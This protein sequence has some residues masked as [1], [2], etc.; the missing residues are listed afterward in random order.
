MLRYASAIAYSIAVSFQAQGLMSP[1]C[2][3]QEGGALAPPPQ[4]GGGEL[5]LLLG[6]DDSN[7]TVGSVKTE[8][9]TDPRVSVAPKDC[10]IVIEDEVHP[11][12]E[13]DSH[14]IHLLSSQRYILL[15]QPK[16]E[17]R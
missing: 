6:L 10:T 3:A 16:K 15:A 9:Y 4:A 11:F 1:K 2:S 5:L 12:E 13:L 7:D 8:V 14:L 17:G